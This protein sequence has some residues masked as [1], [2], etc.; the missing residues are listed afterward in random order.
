[1]TPAEF[2]N[3]FLSLNTFHRNVLKTSH[4]K[5]Q[6]MR[7]ASMLPKTKNPSKAPH[8]KLADNLRTA[9]RHPPECLSAPF[10]AFYG[11]RDSP[12]SGYIKN[13]QTR[14]TQNYTTLIIKLSNALR[15]LFSCVR[16]LYCPSST[17]TSQV[18]ELLLVQFTCVN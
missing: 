18:Q 16:Y 13:I 17:G 15:V 9:A 8:L 5:L 12:K 3:S 7:D 14:V 4:A 2:S 6:N 10:F 1:M 11:V